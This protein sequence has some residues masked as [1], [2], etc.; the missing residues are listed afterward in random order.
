M[1][2]IRSLAV[3]MA[4]LVTLTGRSVNGYPS[5]APVGACDNMAPNHGVVA[6]Q[7]STAPYQLTVSKLVFGC[8]ETLKCKLRY[9]YIRLILT[10]H[11]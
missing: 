11:C 7:T 3:V 10:G 8:K 9:V 4:F 6:G 2:L 1:F 5:G